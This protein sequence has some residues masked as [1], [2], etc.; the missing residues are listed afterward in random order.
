MNDPKNFPGRGQV[1]ILRTTPEA[2]LDDYARLMRLARYTDNLPKANDTLLKI[3]ISW[4]IWYPSCSTTPWQ[5]EAVTKTLL[6]DGYAREKLI[7][8]HNDT[9]VVNGQEGQR[10]NRHK[11]VQDKYGLKTAETYLDDVEWVRY[12]PKRPFLV[13]DKV[14][15]GHGVHIP[16]FFYGKNVL[17][18]PT[19]KCVHPSTEITLADGSLVKIADLIGPVLKQDCPTKDADGD[20]RVPARV[21]LLS[22]SS[23]GAITP[24]STL[25][26]WR[27]PLKGRKIWLVRT[28][29]GRE[30]RV[31]SEHPFLTPLGWH[32][33]MELQVGDRI[34]IPR[35]IPVEGTSQRLP[36]LEKRYGR[37][38]TNWITLPEKTSPEFWRW[39]G[40]FAAEGW[41]QPMKTTCRFWWSNSDPVLQRDFV[42]LTKSLY[43]L[44][45]KQRPDAPNDHYVDSIQLLE[46][47]QT[48]GLGMP[49][50][51]GSK[52]VPDLLFRCPST[53]IAAFL[54]GYF[55]GDAGVGKR[56]G[57]HVITKS[58]TLAKQVQYL[59]N[60]VGVIAFKQ[61]TWNRAAADAPKS[62]YFD[63]AVYGDALVILSRQLR[64][65]ST[66]KPSRIDH[67]VSRHLAS[68]QP[69]NWDT[70]PLSPDSFRTV[71]QGLGFTQASTGR[72]SSVNT[73][74]NGYGLPTRSV[75]QHFIE[76]FRQTDVSGTFADAISEME[77]LAGEDIAWD[78]IEAIQE[79]TADTEYLYDLTMESAPNFIGNGIFL[80]NTHVF[81][82]I[83]GAMKNAFG[84]LLDEKRHW[85]HSVIDETLVDLLQIQQDIHPGIFAVMDGTLAGEGPG[86]RA[87]RW[88]V[89]NVIL[90][91]S[92]P[93]AIDAAAAKIMGVPPMNL[94]FIR[95]AHERGLGVGDPREIKFIGDV[96]AADENWH[97]SA[98][99]NTF[100]S[101]GQY[102][103]YHGFL[104]P[105]EHLLLRTPIV[106]W[107]YAASNFYHNW[108][109]YPFIGKRR[110]QAAL[111]TEWGQLLQTQYS[112]DKPIN[113]GY[114]SRRPFYAATAGGAA[115]ALAFVLG[116]F[117]MTRRGS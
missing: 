49:F 16:K 37:T 58:E 72:P 54:Q 45:V 100:A 83:T 111:Q 75:A 52:R 92:D 117:L 61:S 102:Q 85:T 31:S 12:E 86:P 113:Q 103:I 20:T 71:R 91:S 73:I 41:V 32:R 40:Y 60:R 70:I 62:E 35:K 79:V 78:R 53:E 96:D 74:E 65:Q 4:Q 27:T 33:A 105:F 68:K 87:T 99:E 112:P 97:F 10:N 104:H 29:T 81:T 95:A 88:H 26:F 67:L 24:Q 34:A 42:E 21:E 3:N 36:K 11:F 22:L 114:G 17:H 8:T 9:V 66:H 30:V 14:Y 28:K 110:A 38:S 108:Y 82:H 44:T 50:D 94:R 106:P 63:I 43:G 101:W 48:L 39:F 93:V 47:F 77:F 5:L 23:E 6:A 89:K 115:A 80:H 57:L 51:A 56:D 1:A 59:L 76:R 19:M 15:E 55:D 18:L 109:W 107:S 69:S 7:A 98:Y 46:F 64:L 116:A 25:F 84:G 2:V 90:A 13:L